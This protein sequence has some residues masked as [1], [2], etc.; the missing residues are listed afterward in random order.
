MKI[1]RIH[2]KNQQLIQKPMLKSIH[3]NGPLIELVTGCQYYT[4]LLKSVEIKVKE[5]KIALFLPKI[6]KLLN[7]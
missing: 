4:L 5:T 7:V 3:N 2:N 6:K 1:I